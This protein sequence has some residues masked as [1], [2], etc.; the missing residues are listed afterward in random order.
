MRFA[1][2]MNHKDFALV[3]QIDPP[4]GT[5]T[6]A[7]L[8]AAL[9][10][11]GR[12]D[13]VAFTDNPMATMK[14][15]PLAPC[16]LLR[17]KN[18]E[19]ILT[20]NSRDRNRLSLQSELLAAWALDIRS[21]L[22]RE[23]EDPTYGDHPLTAPCSDL[24][25]EGM[26]D[27]VAAF[28]K[29]TDLSGQPVEGAPSFHAGVYAPLTDDPDANRAR[30]AGLAR[31]AELGARFVVLGS[32]Y[33][34]DTIHAFSQAASRAGIKLIASVLILKSVGM[35][36]YLN[37]VPGVPDIPDEIIQ[38][39]AQAPIKPRAGLEI[40]ADFIRHIGKV[41]DGAFVIPLGWEARVPE[42]LDL[43]NG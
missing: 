42:L 21:V 24:T 6:G 10:F 17:Q 43:M 29:G 16:H 32:T 1:D 12:V 4:K 13:A 41:C 25:L 38:R 31:W 7:L 22:F 19:T 11:R 36:K 26:L 15:H 37:S 33:D 40:A 2:V 35:A 18:V 9:S 3:I 5:A 8:D 20:V 28:R 23:G 30:A 39:I 14:M 34:V 27:A